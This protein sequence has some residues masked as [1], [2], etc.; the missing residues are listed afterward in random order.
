MASMAQSPTTA[1]QEKVIDLRDLPEQDVEAV[2]T[3]VEALRQQEIAQPPIS[4]DE[5]RRRLDAYLQE[6]ASRADRYPPG[7][8]VDDKRETI[9]EGRGE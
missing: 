7:F 3:L 6:V 8:V 2:R 4:S 1:A 9:Y 5:W